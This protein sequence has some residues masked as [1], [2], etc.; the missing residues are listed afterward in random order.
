MKYFTISITILWILIFT[1][2]YQTINQKEET[3]KKG[4][5]GQGK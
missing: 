1:L 3:I 4:Y 5:R 2:Q